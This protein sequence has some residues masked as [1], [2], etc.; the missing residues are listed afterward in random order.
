[1]REKLK[2]NKIDKFLII[3][4]LVKIKVWISTLLIDFISL[5][6]YIAR[7][8]ETHNETGDFT[9]WVVIRSSRPESKLSKMGCAEGL[10][11]LCHYYPSCPEL[12]LTMRTTMHSDKDIGLI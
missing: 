11:A 8:Q 5:Q 2:E 1:M 7:I 3:C 9:V 12:E 6:R 4:T 10:F